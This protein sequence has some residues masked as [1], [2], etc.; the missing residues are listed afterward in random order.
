MKK[1]WITIC[2]VAAVV[3]LAPAGST[4]VASM[5]T[6]TLLNPPSGGLL[7]L[8]VGESH[9]FD[10]EIASEE[11]FILAMALPDQTYPG[12][13]IFFHGNDT[14]HHAT[15]AV[16]HLIVTGKKPTADLPDGVAPAAIVAGARFKR[17]VTVS[18]RFE[19]DVRVVR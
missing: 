18:E 1:L 7:E 17:G 16:L 6:I 12:R 11:P 4:A 10:I 9:T 13:G 14:A 5:T 19:F 3:F 2:V 8:A 15:S